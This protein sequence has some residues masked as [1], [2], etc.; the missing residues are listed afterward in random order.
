MWDKTAHATKKTTTYSAANGKL[1]FGS[2]IAQDAA[3]KA[4]GAADASDTT[5]RT[6]K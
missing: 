4:A 2:A 3:S 1:G 6:Q 5:A